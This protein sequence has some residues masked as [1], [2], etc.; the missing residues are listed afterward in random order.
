MPMMPPMGGG[1]GS[2]NPNSERSDSSGL[3]GG[4]QQPWSGDETGAV[5]G[6]AGSADGTAAG[7][8]GLT[9]SAPQAVV[10][11]LPAVAVASEPGSATEPEPVHKAEKKAAPEPDIVPVLGQ[12]VGGEDH[13]A[14]EV[15]A[16]AASALLGLSGL[17][18]TSG[19]DDREIDARIVSSETDAW[20]D[21]E[22]PV[23]PPD[24]AVP[25]P[26][27]E[28]AMA[29]WRRTASAAP[30]TAIRN[31]DLRSGR[32]PPGYEPPAPPEQEE[33][34][35]EE[36]EEEPEEDSG[37][38]AAKLLTQDSSTWGRRADDLSALE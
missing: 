4:V 35:V 11:V 26:D 23:A 38:V 2:Q 14:W 29:T 13:S 37:T 20:I 16:S 5:A 19:P 25:G 7:G 32:F 3:L 21:E 28:P 8:V 15:G 22:P 36:D 9:Q 33:E 27:D 6:E 31:P 18:R 24:G 10:P 30:V 17:L 12:P 34:P 1:A